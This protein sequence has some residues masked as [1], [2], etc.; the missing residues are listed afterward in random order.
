M[1][2]IPLSDSSIGRV[3]LFNGPPSSG[4]TSLVNSLQHQISAPWFHLSLDDFRPG[5]SESFWDEDEG[6]LFSRLLTGYVGALRE[7][8]LAGNDVLAEAVITPARRLLYESTFG[9]LPLLLIG[10][11]CR[12]DIAVQR[13]VSRAD[14]RHGP[15]ELPAA[16]FAAVQS[17]PGCRVIS[18]DTCVPISRLADC[19]LDSVA[20]AEASGIPYFLVGHVGDGNFHLVLLFDPKD[21]RE[22]QKA[23]DIAQ[24]VSARAIAMG[25]TCTGEHGIGMHKL[26]AL[27]TEHG[28]GA[29]DLMRRIKRALDPLDILNPGKTV[30]MQNP[31]QC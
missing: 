11:K 31:R 16:Y 20:E 25:G 17:R 4:K 30:P 1:G 21:P 18:T 10:V 14:R 8:A 3:A 19:L 27:V 13:E 9:S 12:L 22:R 24:R 2:A 23:E 15:I 29:V 6:D 7:M 28:E 5:Y 26:D